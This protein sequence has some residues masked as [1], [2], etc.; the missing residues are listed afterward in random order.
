MLVC[1]I[2]AI[3]LPLPPPQRLGNRGFSP[4]GYISK[5][6]FP[7]ALE[8]LSWLMKPTRGWKKVHISKGQR[9]FVISVF[10]SECCKKG[11]VR[12]LESGRNLS[13]VEAR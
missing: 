12:G 5:G 13:R 7:S 8:R 6:G 10:L 1:T 3:C 2:E 11:V 9:K 4:D